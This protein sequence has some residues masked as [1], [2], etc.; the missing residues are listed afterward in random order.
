M[1]NNLLTIVDIKKLLKIRL[2]WTRMYIVMNK[3]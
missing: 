3:I 1:H 2:N